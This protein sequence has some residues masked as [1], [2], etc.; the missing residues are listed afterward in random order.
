[1]LFFLCQNLI[2]ISA[3]WILYCSST[4]SYTSRRCI[5][6]YWCPAEV[7]IFG[8]GPFDLWWPLFIS[9]LSK[10]WLNHRLELNIKLGCCKNTIYP[11]T[12]CIWIRASLSLTWSSPPMSWTMGALSMVW[13]ASVLRPPPVPPWSHHQWPLENSPPP[14]SLSTPRRWQSTRA[15]PTPPTGTTNTQVSWVLDINQIIR[16]Y[17][18]VFRKTEPKI[19]ILD[20]QQQPVFN[21]EMCALRGSIIILG[22][23]WLGWLAGG[24][25]CYRP[26]PMS[27]CQH[28]NRNL[29]DLSLAFWDPGL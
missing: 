5:S 27:Q 16:R 7:F 9:I 8:G 14:H 23:V 28:I 26:L 2:T 21:L 17:F 24:W 29:G 3:D 20:C 10:Q 4:R 13:L 25:K 12:W 19:C 15:Q 22:L 1:M 18:G 11:C 6:L